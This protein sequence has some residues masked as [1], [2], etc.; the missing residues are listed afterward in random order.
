MLFRS[1]VCLIAALFAAV[2]ALLAFMG[3]VDCL[4]EPPE[5]D[6]WR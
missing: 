4:C 5:F 3:W 6:P 2:L 1:M